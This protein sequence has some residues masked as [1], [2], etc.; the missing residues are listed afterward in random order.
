MEAMRKSST[1]ETL[2]S[3]VSSSRSRLGGIPWRSQIST[4]VPRLAIVGV[5]LT[6]VGVFSVL[7]PSTF[8]TYATFVSL[9]VANSTVL[10][11]ALA[12]TTTLRSGDFDVSVGAM[13]IVSAAVA[14]QSVRVG[15]G[16]GI[17]LLLALGLAL[18]VGMINAFIVVICGLDS[19]IATLGTMTVLVG[20]GFG[21][22]GSS[23]VTGY[24]GSILSIARSEL[25][26]IPSQVYIGWAV[27]VILLYVFGWTLLGRQWL[28]IGGNREAARLLGLRVRLLRSSAF[29]ITS[30]ISGAAGVLL[31]GSVGS[32]DPSSSGEYLLGPVAAAFLG[33][34]AISIGKFNV[35]GT[36]LGVYTLGLG[37]AG[38]SLFGA[39]PWISNVFNGGTLILALGFSAVLQ[40]R[41]RVSLRSL[42][43]TSREVERLSPS[44]SSPSDQ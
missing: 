4:H 15:W 26:Q 11:L 7:E 23:V 16:L 44:T 10:L 32:V 29:C 1:K 21:I 24:G 31:A 20:V 34:A 33:T 30:V 3:L 42:L 22:T 19:F 17:A 12:V 8:P 18:I 13:T 9:L 35:L 36:V 2:P 25:W 5:M 6:L 43:R 41:L 37:E 27:A 39:P 28:F 14:A 38:L 40:G